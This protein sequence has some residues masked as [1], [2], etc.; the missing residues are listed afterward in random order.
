MQKMRSEREEVRCGHISTTYL[1]PMTVRIEY[2]R[3]QA[4]L[5]YRK[6]YIYQWNNGDRCLTVRPSS[7]F[8]CA[9]LL[10]AVPADEMAVAE[11]ISMFCFTRNVIVFDTWLT[12][13][14]V[15]K[16]GSL[17]WTNFL[18]LYWHRYQRRF[19]P[20]HIGSGN[21]IITYCPLLVW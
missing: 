13:W 3:L 11:S 1:T 5:D 18:S 8:Q 10:I 7:R 14:P 2:T 9:D 12:I 15:W 16:G 20:G 17:A 6:Y 4:V 19:V 21:K